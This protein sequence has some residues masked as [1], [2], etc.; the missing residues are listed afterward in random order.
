[1]N[2]ELSGWLQCK[3]NVEADGGDG[4]LGGGQRLLNTE[5]KRNEPENEM[6][7]Q[8]FDTARSF[9]WAVWVKDGND[10]KG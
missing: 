5:K 6:S 9:S 8:V 10:T 2:A 7:I 3:N 1:M 4:V